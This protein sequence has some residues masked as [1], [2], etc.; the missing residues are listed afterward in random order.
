MATTYD[1]ADPHDPRHPALEPISETLAIAV[2]GDHPRSHANRIEKLLAGA[3][4]VEG[5]EP[6]ADEARVLVHYDA[7]R[8]N[9][10]ELHE[11]LLAHGY[12]AATH[13]D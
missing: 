8:T 3:P 10:A 6:H 1:P 7:R 2:E 4:G 5:V 9:P 11:Q 12:K 13:A